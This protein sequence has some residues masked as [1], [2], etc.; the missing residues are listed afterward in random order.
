MF[1]KNDESMT[2]YVSSLVD[3][4][5]GKIRNPLI[6][7][8]IGVWLI[9]N[10]VVVYAIFIFDD[11]RTMQCEISFITNYFSKIGF[12]TEL[13]ICFI[14]ALSLLLITFFLLGISRFVRDL[15][16]KTIE[17]F[18]I[19]KIDK[20]AIFTIA[21]KNILDTRITHLEA[22]IDKNN[23]TISKAEKINELLEERIKTKDLNYDNKLQS[24]KDENKK[25]EKE[26]NN[27][28][29]N[30]LKIDEI[31]ELF[32]KNYGSLNIN[33][34]NLIEDIRHNQRVNSKLKSIQQ[35]KDLLGLVDLGFVKFVPD[36]DTYE[37]TPLGI[38]Y[39]N[40]Y[41]LAFKQKNDL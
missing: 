33:M 19:A 18:I 20:N 23:D 1:V 5:K 16:Y 12:K 14:S 22:K 21:D 17:P 26:R 34:I 15:Y 10:W 40:G 4:Y 25:I 32:K 24:I 30:N 27:L 6:G 13:L 36:T 37:L 3:N 28:K 38:V 8:I 29:L 35:V 2:D 11:D 41:N 9:R 31:F 7:T 39:L